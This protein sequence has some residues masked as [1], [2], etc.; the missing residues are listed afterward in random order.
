M[1]F[2]ATILL[3]LISILPACALMGVPESDVEA[4]IQH[5]AYPVKNAEGATER[6][7]SFMDDC[8]VH[9]K[10]P[11]RGEG[12]KMTITLDDDC[13]KVKFNVNASEVDPTHAQTQYKEVEQARSEERKELIKGVREYLE[14]F[15]AA[16]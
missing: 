6:Y 4:R 11:A 9:V 12:M 16:P 13:R 14:K 5:E 10:S 2:K 1:K 7:D 3:I 15:P 8:W